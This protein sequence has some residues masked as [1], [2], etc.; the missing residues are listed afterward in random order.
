MSRSPKLHFPLQVAITVLNKFLIAL[1]HATPSSHWLITSI[2]FIKIKNYGALYYATLFSLLLI[3]SPYI[4]IIS[5]SLCSKTSQRHLWKHWWPINLLRSFR[6]LIILDAVLF[7]YKK[8][9]YFLMLLANLKQKT[10]T[11][12]TAVL[13]DKPLLLCQKPIMRTVVYILV[14]NKTRRPSEVKIW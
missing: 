7:L 13:P 1:T 2:K 11:S 4:K 8:W 6:F 12:N 14:L 3:Y 5:S 10:L 9:Y